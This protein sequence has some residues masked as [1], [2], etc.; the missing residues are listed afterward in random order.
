MV[1]PT[2]GVIWGGTRQP[3]GGRL[4]LSHTDH[5]GI[6]IFEEAHAQGLRAARGILRALANS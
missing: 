4:W 2:P 6:S 1:T 5:G 3:A